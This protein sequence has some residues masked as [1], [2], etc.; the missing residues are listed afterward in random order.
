MNILAKLPTVGVFLFWA[1][2]LLT[3]V[4]VVLLSRSLFFSGP[5]KIPEDLHLRDTYYV[6]HSPLVL[7]LALVG[8]V[9]ISVAGWL[10][11]SAEATAKQI[12]NE[13]SSLSN[14]AADPE[15]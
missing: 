4:C 12:L 1:G 15:I 7:V 8:A 6:Q 14:R 11:M 3:F 5:P 10:R 2:G 9:L 13:L